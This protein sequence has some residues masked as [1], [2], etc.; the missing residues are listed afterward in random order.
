[1][2]FNVLVTDQAD[3]HWK[4]ERLPNCFCFFTYKRLLKVNIV[5]TTAEGT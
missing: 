4:E 2:C 3:H 5:Q 1:M